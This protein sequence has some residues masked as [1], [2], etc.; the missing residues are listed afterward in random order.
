MKVAVFDEATNSHPW[1]QFA[2]Q[3]DVGIRGY[4]ASAGEAFENAARAMTSV[5]TP[6]GLLSAKET[7]RI[8]CQAPNLEILFVDWLNALI[9][10][11]CR[12]ADFGLPVDNRPIDHVAA[13]VI[14]QLACVEVDKPQ[15]RCVD[16]RPTQDLIVGHGNVQIR[17]QIGYCAHEI[18]GIDP[19]RLKPM[20]LN[21]S[22]CNTYLPEPK[23]F[24][25]EADSR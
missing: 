12:E 17:S 11:M 6:I 16:N 2:H 22:P 10:E 15:P 4:G 9:Y 21:N 18:W 20:D 24:D 3:G 14:G 8:R 7:T 5:V 13:A 1:T 25:P 19:G 23:C